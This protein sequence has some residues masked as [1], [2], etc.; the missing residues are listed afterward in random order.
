MQLAEHSFQE[1]GQLTG[2]SVVVV[3][4]KTYNP[5]AHKGALRRLSPEEVNFARIVGI[6]NAIKN[7]ASEDKLKRFR[8]DILNASFQF[9]YHEGGVTNPEHT[10]LPRAINLR[11]SMRQTAK[12]RQLKL[13]CPT[14][15]R[16]RGAYVC[17]E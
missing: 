8:L 9:E 16:L 1:P 2:T 3:D 7:N 5:L 12:A 10:L 15:L 6:H 14:V 13:C 11:E 4:S 17:S